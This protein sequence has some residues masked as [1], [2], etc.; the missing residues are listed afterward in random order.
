MEQLLTYNLLEPFEFNFLF[1]PA[2]ENT[3]QYYF[4]N[5]VE[6]WIVGPRSDHF[7]Y[8][9]GKCVNPIPVCLAAANIRDDVSAIFS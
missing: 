5:V 7:A 4:Q 6:L 2:D 8:K 9:T 3:P 1:A